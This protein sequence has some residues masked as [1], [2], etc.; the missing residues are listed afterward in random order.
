MKEETNMNLEK[1][2]YR[3]RD[4]F[5]SGKE[6]FFGG[7]RIP[8]QFISRFSLEQQFPEFALEWFD[9]S[10]SE[11]SILL[12]WNFDD[13]IP[14]D[15][16][17]VTI[18]DQEIQIESSSKRGFTFALREIGNLTKS[19]RNGIVLPH[20]SIED[21]PGFSIRGI[22]EGFYGE[23]WSFEERKDMISFLSKC[24][25]N[26][27]FYA[28]KDDL[29]HRENWRIPYPDDIF[30]N[31]LSLKTVCD[32]NLIDFYYCISPG[33]DFDYLSEE[34]YDMLFSKLDAMIEIGISH[35][36]ILLDDIDYTLKSD[37][38]AKFRRTGLAHAHLL[39]RI[40]DYLRKKLHHYFLTAC[41]TEY[42]SYWDTAYKKD[43]KQTVHE[44]I[45]LFWTGYNT[46]AESI[47]A[48]HAKR[49]AEYLG[50]DLILWDNYPC[51][52]VNLNRLFLGPNVNRSSLLPQHR[53]IGVAANPM[54]QMEA[55]KVPL[56][57]FADYMWNPQRYQPELSWEFAL[58]RYCG[59]DES[60]KT[61]FKLNKSL[62]FY[63]FQNNELT[64]AIT[65]KDIDYLNC[66]F[67][68]I[69]EMALDL[70]KRDTKL[71]AEIRPWLLRAQQDVILWELLRE[72][73]K[74]KLQ[75]DTQR[76]SIQM[77]AC[78][79]HAAQ[80]GESTAVKAAEAWG[81]QKAERKS[82]YAQR[83]G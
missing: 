33:K 82:A 31:I 21:Y 19:C 76:I 3:H 75:N 18:S 60:L 52:D 9:L 56:M 71:A 10:R 6:T 67:S 11:G 48:Q 16:Y 78:D 15:G 46:I 81:Y 83:G 12:K 79:H 24:R 47:P 58:E 32:K 30:Q 34:D 28:P 62:R 51:N 59:N 72:G 8:V 70:L 1:V 69:R 61:F 4:I 45:A 44:N 57:T 68:K 41:P 22:I 39:N 55:S 42:W 38:E 77:A 73:E 5:L 53:H 43:L 27:Y 29:Y 26:T 54:N 25:M 13:D 80:L 50:H 65:N 2:F 35:F 66:Y 14:E 7:E 37:H 49:N 23:P 64:E 17:R 63:E 36:G 20:L 40:D 74:S